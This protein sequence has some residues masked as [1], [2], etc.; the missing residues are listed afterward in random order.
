MS[1]DDQDDRELEAYLKGD[2]ALSKT[3]RALAREEPSARLDRVILA[4]SR[5]ALRRRGAHHPFASHWMV[6][7]SLA[8]VLL[9]GIGLVSLIPYESDVF[10]PKGLS[11]ESDTGP[12]EGG[13]GRSADEV[14]SNAAAEVESEGRLDVLREE[15]GAGGQ[16]PAR[17]AAPAEGNV[18]TRQRQPL[19]DETAQKRRGMK[20]GVMEEPAPAAMDESVDYDG[21]LGQS[22]DDKMRLIRIGMSQA[23]V[24]R[25]LGEPV[26]PEKMVW[27]YKD[28][29]MEKADAPV[30]LYRIYFEHGKVHRVEGTSAPDRAGPKP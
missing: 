19:E 22:L 2:S 15:A 17:R 21:Y 9:I 25:L 5:R 23:E 18:E 16:A 30:T 4:K 12:P 1:K 11:P 28:A 24:R 27:I 7:V 26:T 8:A 10:A 29:R 13:V 14:K 3:Y 6:P 20:T